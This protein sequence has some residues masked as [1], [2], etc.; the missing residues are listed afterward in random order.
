M[1]VSTQNTQVEALPPINS[2]WQ[3]GFVVIQSLNRVRLFASPWTA[4]RQASHLHHLPEFAQIH[5]H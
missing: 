3:W 2:I 5:V 4:A 1:L